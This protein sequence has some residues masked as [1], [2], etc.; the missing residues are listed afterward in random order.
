MRVV[1]VLFGLVLFL[2]SCF[3][4]KYGCKCYQIDF[5]NNYAIYYIGK[6]TNPKA[7]AEC[8]AMEDDLN[9]TAVIPMQCDEGIYTD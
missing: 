6:K 4:A 8:K 1:I 7:D 2:S 5:P 3:K 9:K